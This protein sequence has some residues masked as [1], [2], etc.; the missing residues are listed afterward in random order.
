MSRAFSQR[1]KKL[2]EE[3]YTRKE[4]I[5]RTSYEELVNTPEPFTVF[6]F[7]SAAKILDLRIDFDSISSRA[8]YIV[9]KLVSR[10]TITETRERPGA[11]SVHFSSFE[12]LSGDKLF[13]FVEDED[14]TLQAVT[15][16]LTEER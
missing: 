9:A 7:S 2:R 5:G 3:A 4:K 6:V 14:I 16:S 8:T 11:N 15:T 13:L 12:V 10:N 1:V